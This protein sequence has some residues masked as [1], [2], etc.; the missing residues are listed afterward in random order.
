MSRSSSVMPTTRLVH[1]L[2][3][4]GLAAVLLAGC[5]STARTGGN[6]AAGVSSAQPSSPFTVQN[7][8]QGQEYRTTALGNLPLIRMQL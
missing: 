2:A 1:A 3:I 4:T 8:N 7:R 6:Q 5:S